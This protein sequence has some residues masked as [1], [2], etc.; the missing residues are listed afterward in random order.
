MANW[1]SGVERSR[2]SRG[3]LTRF[4]GYDAMFF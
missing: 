1:A 4:N 2:E 3:F